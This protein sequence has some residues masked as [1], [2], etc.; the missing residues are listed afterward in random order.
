MSSQV[1]VAFVAIDHTLCGL[2]DDVLGCRNRVC[3]FGELG[4]DEIDV[5]GEDIVG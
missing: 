4:K 5:G 3:K 1:F 2:F